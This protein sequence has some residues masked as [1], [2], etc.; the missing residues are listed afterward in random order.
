MFN[1]LPCNSVIAQSIACTCSA[2]CL[3][4]GENCVLVFYGFVRKD[5]ADYHVYS[6]SYPDAIWKLQHPDLHAY[7]FRFS[8]LPHPHITALV[9]KSAMDWELLNLLYIALLLCGMVIE[10]L[11]I[12]F[13]L[14]L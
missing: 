11:P 12:I 3:V 2:I 10:H 13:L 5:D 14:D 8:P 6:N 9:C 1:Q 7:P 4:H